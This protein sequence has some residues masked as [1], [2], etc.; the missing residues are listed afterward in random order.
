MCII[1]ALENKNSR[2]IIK[3]FLAIFFGIA[4]LSGLGFV[5]GMGCSAYYVTNSL[6]LTGSLSWA[7][8]SPM[9]QIPV[10]LIIFCAWAAIPLFGYQYNDWM[11]DKLDAILFK[12]R[13]S[14][15]KKGSQ[16]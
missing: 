2:T 15:R 4:I 9:W 7:L 1:K 16:G 5:M 10:W 3:V 13:L 6:V 12:K 14:S 8:F 11:D